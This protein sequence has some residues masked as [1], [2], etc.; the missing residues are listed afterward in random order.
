LCAGYMSTRPRDLLLPGK[1]TSV[2]HYLLPA[3]CVDHSAVPIGTVI[4]L[5]L[6]TDAPAYPSPSSDFSVPAGKHSAQWQAQTVNCCQTIQPS[7]RP[8]KYHSDHGDNVPGLNLLNANNLVVK[9]KSAI[10]LMDRSCTYS[11]NNHVCSDTHI[12]HYIY[13]ACVS[14]GRIPVSLR[15][16]SISFVRSPRVVDR[17]LSAT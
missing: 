15:I 16:V 11:L 3:K 1:A 9:Q 12:L 13:A 6:G 5:P 7:P 8:Y 10:R 4:P 14:N 17:T 2:T